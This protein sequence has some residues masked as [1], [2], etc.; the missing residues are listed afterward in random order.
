MQAKASVCDQGFDVVVLKKRAN[1]SIF[2]DAFVHPAVAAVC[3]FLS[4]CSTRVTQCRCLLPPR[5]LEPRQESEPFLGDSAGLVNAADIIYDDNLSDSDVP[6]KPAT[7]SLDAVHVYGSTLKEAMLSID[8]YLMFVIGA[9]WTGSG[10]LLINNI[11]QIA[12]SLNCATGG[13]VWPCLPAWLRVCPCVH[14]K[15]CACVHLLP[16]RMCTSPSSPWRTAGAV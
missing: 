1:L 8:F 9:A 15:L 10:L 16:R 14:L 12:I 7:L 4:T 5:S 3:S 11:S 6:H 13:Q 2:L